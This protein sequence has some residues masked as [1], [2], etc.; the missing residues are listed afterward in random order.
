[1]GKQKFDDRSIHLEVFDRVRRTVG[2]GRPVYS[3]KSFTFLLWKEKRGSEGPSIGSERRGRSIGFSRSFFVENVVRLVFP[4]R[5]NEGFDIEGS[6]GSKLKKGC[7]R[8]FLF[9]L[10]FDVFDRVVIFDGGSLYVFW[11]SRSFFIGEKGKR[12]FSSRD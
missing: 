2:D 6:N 5:R 11:L 3:E 4:N 10:D 8:R 9:G 7:D 1:M 12:I